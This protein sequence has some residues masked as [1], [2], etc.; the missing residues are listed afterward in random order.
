M[1][2]IFIVNESIFDSKSLMAFSLVLL[3]GF[4]KGSGIWLN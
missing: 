3:S 4:F 1:R 2:S